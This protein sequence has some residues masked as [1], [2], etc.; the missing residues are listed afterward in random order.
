MMYVRLMMALILVLGMPI[1]H[2]ASHGDAVADAERGQLK[3]MLQSIEQSINA[4]DMDSLGRHLH[5]DVVVTFLNAEVA[6]GVPA[7]GEYFT[8]MLGSS[9]AVLKSFRTEATE[10]APARLYGDIA[11]A[12][13]VTRDELVFANGSEMHFDSL[14]STTLIKQAGQWKVLS[15][16]FSTN[17]FD[18]PVLAALENNTLTIAAVAA[19]ISLIIGFVAGRMTRRS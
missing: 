2:A 6:R 5:D 19:L 12:E 16:H 4:G 10:S 8:R 17:V 14:W 9:S 7:V 13:G 18:N 15:L 11:V 1:S 3:A